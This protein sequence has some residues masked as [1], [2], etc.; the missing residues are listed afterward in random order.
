MKLSSV[1]SCVS[2]RTG[3]PAVITDRIY[4]S[5]PTDPIKTSHHIWIRSGTAGDEA[6][7]G[8]HTF[9]HRSTTDA[10]SA[11]RDLSLSK[12]NHNRSDGTRS[13][14]SKNSRP[15]EDARK[16]V[17]VLT[18][19]TLSGLMPSRTNLCRILLSYG[20][21]LSS[22]NNRKLQKCVSVYVS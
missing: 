22:L 4:T 11:S 3:K 17:F 6:V 18:S 9:G 20:S 10:A 21:K 12:P 14:N 5:A 2:G 13:P 16:N 15:N 7:A 1:Q 19:Q 8:S